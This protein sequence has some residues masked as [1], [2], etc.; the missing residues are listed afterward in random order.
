LATVFA[1]VSAVG[2]D[3]AGSFTF[4]GTS[5]ACGQAAK[6]RTAARAAVSLNAN[7]KLFFFIIFFLLKNTPVPGNR[8]RGLHLLF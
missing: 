2:V 8:A 1:F 5:A 3:D 7:T 4:G 6:Q